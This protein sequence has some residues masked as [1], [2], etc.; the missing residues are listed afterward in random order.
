MDGQDIVGVRLAKGTGTPTPV[1]PSRGGPVA[2][3]AR[4]C[5]GVPSRYPL[6]L[7]SS[8]SPSVPLAPSPSL[9]LPLASVLAVHASSPAEMTERCY[10]EE[11]VCTRESSRSRIAALPRP[12]L[13][14]PAPPR[15][16]L[17]CLPTPT[18]LHPPTTLRVAGRS[19]FCR[20]GAGRALTNFIRATVI[21]EHGRHAT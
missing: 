1:Q 17:P 5:R 18:P 9:P 21:I 3:A 8:P 6:Y 2:G 10:S 12:C 11:A 16:A 15:P 14:T 19:L 13:L 20:G 7:A 4:P